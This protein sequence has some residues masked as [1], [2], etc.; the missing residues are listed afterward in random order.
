M[1]KCGTDGHPLTPLHCATSMHLSLITHLPIKFLTAQLLHS[2][3]SMLSTYIASHCS[4]QAR[5]HHHH[6]QVR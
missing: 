5:R 4:Y 1:I 3:A 6:L 2:T